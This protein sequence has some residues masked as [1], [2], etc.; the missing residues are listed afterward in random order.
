MA[1]HLAVVNTAL[2][3]F[4]MLA[5]AL[6]RCASPLGPIWTRNRVIA[7]IL[8]ISTRRPPLYLQIYTSMTLLIWMMLK[9]PSLPMKPFS[10]TVS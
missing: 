6:H 8:F 9:P 10:C 5:I 4:H 7:C 1:Y 2:F 3:K